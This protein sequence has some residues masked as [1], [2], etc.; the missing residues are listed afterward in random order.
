[1][2]VHRWKRAATLL[3]LLAMLFAALPTHSARAATVVATVAGSFQSEIG[4]TDDWQPSCDNSLMTDGDGDGV[5]T[6]SVAA[7]TLPVGKYEYKVALNR[8]WD[9]SYPT[10]NLAFRISAA[11]NAVTFSY[12]SATNE[13]SHQVTGSKPPALDGDIYWDG[14]GHDSREL[15]Y[16]VPGGAVPANS[17]VKL[18]FR[19]YHNDVSGVTLRT[20]HTGLGAE[21]LIEMKRV[22]SGV[23]CYNPELS[24]SCDFWEATLDSSTIGTIYYRFIV[25]DGAKT[26]YYE[27]DSDVRDGGW[28]QT[29]DNSNDWGWA[30]TVY[31]P[32]FKLPIQWMKEGVVYQI[33][34]DR[35]RNAN[36]ANDPTPDPTNPRLSTDPRYAYPNGEALTDTEPQYDQIVRMNWG[37]L[38]EGYCRNYQDI[39]DA[40]CPKRFAQPGSGKEQPRGRDYYGG[41]LA[42]VTE[43][44]GYLKQLGVTV[45]YFNPIFAAGSNHRYDTRD[46]KIIDP[47]LG[48]L[49]D[50]QTLER[51]AQAQGIRIILDG[52]FNHMSSD[53]PFFDRY[54]NWD[55]HIQNKPITGQVKLSPVL[56]CVTENNGTYTAYFGYS[57]PNASTVTLNVGADNKFSPPPQDRGQPTKFYPGRYRNIVKVTFDGNA[58]V[59]KL[60]SSTATASRNSKRCSSFDPKPTPTPESFLG[61]CESVDSPYRHWFRFRKPNANEPAACAPY[62]RDGDSY[63][64]SWAGFDSLPQLSEYPDVQNYIFGDENSVARY[65]LK[66][67][68]DGWRLDVMQDKSIPFWEGFR[69]QVKDVNPDAIIIGE[70]WKKFDVLPYINGNTAD[71]AMNY[72]LRDAVL[73]LLAPGSFDSKGFPGSGNPITPS[74]FAE[75]LDSVREDYPDAAYYTLMNLLDSHDTERLLWTLTPG[76]ENTE[77]R[78]LNAANVAEGKQR[79]RLAAM[80][81]MTMPGAPTIYYGDEVAL[82]GDD[83][84]DDRRTY[85]WGDVSGDTRQPDLQMLQYYTSLTQL[86]NQNQA[87]INGD[88]QF[89]LTDDANGTVAY[90]RKAGDDAAI[91]ALNRSKQQRSLTIPVSGYLPNGTQLTG[92]VGSTQ[93]TFTVQSG[94][95]TIDLPALAGVVLVTRGADLT[96]T[97]APTS[98]QATANNLSID[99]SWSSVAS[100]AGYNVYR[101]PVS[102][103]GYVKIN[104]SPVTGTSYTDNSNELISGQRYYYVVKALDSVSNE[105]A[106]SNEAS[107][108]PSYSIGWANLQWPPTLDY[109]VSAVNTTDTVYGQ[110]WIDGVTNQSGATPGLIAQ[111]GYGPQGSDPRTWNT[112]VDMEFNTDSGHNDEYKGTLQ[113]T[114]PGTYSYFT[115]YSTNAGE[116]WT[117]GDLDGIESG[118]FANQTDSPGTLTVRANT[119]QT[120]PSAP[121]NLQVFNNGATSIALTWDAVTA[122]DLYRYDVYRSTT[123]GSGYTKIGTAAKDATSFTDTGLQ[124]GTRYYYVLRAVD[125][126]N[127]VS[128]NSNE[129]SAVP[130]ARNVQV[131]FEVTVPAGTPSDRTVYIVGNQPQICNWC[132]P[133]TV[134]LTKGTDGKWRV[135]LTFLEG[136]LVEYKYTL[137]SWDYVEKDAS[138]SCGEIGNRQLRV[139]A[140]TNG[141]QLKE[142]TVANWRNISPCGS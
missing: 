81:Q 18:R 53:S 128:G 47:Y 15:L 93:S 100:A 98:L 137:G 87:F 90:G 83:D 92:T 96:P 72:R 111:L 129:A 10:N 60:T 141:A 120:A 8:A 112:W 2:C 5:Y 38:P 40:E 113:P 73:G 110:I 64:D 33:F 99:L 138:A 51:A 54:H 12:N 107:A 105:S 37:E 117:Y 121:S 27:D 103:G 25:K 29:F 32:N 4:C 116:S 17:K 44:L 140:G 139:V 9:S 23:S 84:P 85:P 45:I 74:A 30:L 52:V 127:N 50:W 94:V 58:L 136:T 65:W 13:V 78:E 66:Q 135:T 41:D 24:W 118:S 132:N 57:N 19:T 86:R 79:Q 89:L 39:S 49:G 28:G 69:E 67:G 134:A 35:F 106:A 1:M 55:G 80:I 62:T 63:Y 102:G 130:E 7:G 82:T 56:E 46:F 108:V 20:Y 126:A 104:N 68:A 22:A 123:S 76:V 71:T 115:R 31:D 75:R 142:D 109:T 36:P 61:A 59:W 16:R 124:T 88:L 11:D 26:V 95:I 119:D 14:L 97:G 114:T 6:F 101:S 122:S 131:T 91:V 43:K 77:G 70:L 42:G 133:H 48:N 3:P 21:Q 34:P 125:E